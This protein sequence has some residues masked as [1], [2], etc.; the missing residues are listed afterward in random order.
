MSPMDQKTLPSGGS[1]SSRDNCSV[2]RD[3]MIPMRDG[4]LLATDIYFPATYV[5]SAKQQFPVILE[6]TPYGK[7]LPSRS[8]RTAQSE[9]TLSRDEVAEFFVRQGYIVIYQDC[10][11]RYRS[12]GYFVKYTSDG[13][14]GYDTCA[15]IIARP[16]SN[17]RIGT[18]GL[19]YAAHTQAA[20]ASLNAPGVVA[21]FLDSGGFSNA[22]QGGI[23]QGGAFEM[24]QATWALK[25][26]LESPAI[27]ADKEKFTQLSKVDIA[28]WF[29]HT[30]DWEPGHSPLSLAPDY[31]SYLFDQW[32]HGAFDNY[33][34][35]IG[36][37]AEGYHQSFP[38]AAM[39]HM[40]SWYDPYPRTA[41]AN[42]AGLTKYKKGPVC[43]VLGPWTHGNRSISYSG[44]VDFGSAAILDESLAPSFLELRLRWFDKWLKQDP[45]ARSPL[46]PV[47]IFVMG[48]GSGRRNSA[49]RLDHGG[50]WRSELEWPIPDTRLTHY[51]LGAEEHLSLLQPNESE[52]SLSYRYDPTN[53]VPTIGG[54]VTSGQPLMFGGAYDQRE[55]PTV[56]AAAEPYKALSEREDV[57][58]FQTQPL[59]DD[60]E[61]T[62]D[63][64]ATLWISS[65]CTDT[66]FTFKLIDVYP[67]STDYPNGYAMNL[68]DGILRVRYRES[69]ESPELM[70]PGAVYKI[71]IDAFPTSN[72]FKKGH[73]IRI[74]ISSSNFPKFDCNPN[75]GG[76]EGCAT[77]TLVATNH[78]Y[79]DK[80]RPSHVTLPIIP[81]RRDAAGD[82]AQAENNSLNS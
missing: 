42:Y 37:Y 67:S 59:D 70:S 45:N 48:G 2:V 44:D 75:T 63:I 29:R 54:A 13:E 40:S 8:E 57:L 61:V 78:I 19:S 3:V 20:L 71:R 55:G 25:Q 80:D 38:D 12:Q 79:F 72:L 5:D 14:D 28:Q 60:I 9:A 50:T 15:W 23:R 64:S 74:D 68:T 73:R 82:K 32:R 6:R 18:I 66:D 10:R 31:E 35:Q 46:P 81:K 69:W 65:D 22:F 16:W 7:H 30:A 4:V 1:I 11:G 52:N 27:R 47:S 53:P 77:K 76:P 36:L 62:G 39:V 33:W 17:G 24:K 41:C 21:M 51:Y 26:A 34:K 43:L 56:F 58:V 49:G